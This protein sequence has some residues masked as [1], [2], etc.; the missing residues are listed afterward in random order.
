MDFVWMEN[1][2]INPNISLDQFVEEVVFE[3]NYATDYYEIAYPGL[4][5]H[6]HLSR[7]INYHLLQTY[8]PSTMFV[9][10]AWLS[11]FVNPEAIPGRISMVMMTLLTL[12]AMFS[13]VRQNTPKV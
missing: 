3:S 4:I 7:K 2:N 6:I 9:T 10:I 8:I 12:M 13:G 11:L 5:L 1:N